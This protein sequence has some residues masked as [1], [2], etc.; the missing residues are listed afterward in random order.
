MSTQINVVVDGGG[1]VDRSKEQTQANRWAKAEADA[2]Q[3]ALDEGFKQREAV[4]KQ[5]GLSADSEPLYGAASRFKRWQD[6]PTA[7]LRGIDVGVLGRFSVYQNRDGA[8]R[9][10]VLEYFPFENGA[11][12]ET[13]TLIET[14]AS[15]PDLSSESLSERFDASANF[16]YLIERYPTGDYLGGAAVNDW[17]L[18]ESDIV[19]YP[20]GE[21]TRRY[22]RRVN[23]AFAY[24][25]ALLPVARNVFIWLVYGYAAQSTVDF[26]S[27]FRLV[28]DIV[29]TG[30][31][32][33]LP[34][35]SKL[36]QHVFT[37]RQT[38]LTDERLESFD[39]ISIRKAFLVNG[40]TL[41]PISFPNGVWQRLKT[42]V[43]EPLPPLASYETIQ[44][45]TVVGFT[46]PP[47]AYVTEMQPP[48]ILNSTLTP[49]QVNASYNISS[50]EDVYSYGYVRT[51]IDETLWTPGVYSL[52][53]NE[54]IPT[55]SPTSKG[56][57][58]V[59]RPNSSDFQWG[60]VRPFPVPAGSTPF[61]KPGGKVY[62]S[63]PYAFTWDW[64]QPWYCRQQL[65]SLGFALEDLT[66]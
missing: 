53:K 55:P 20:V 45:E 19:L 16:D 38:T 6:E 39:K 10:W 1:L 3:A 56:A 24:D 32:S 23:T 21:T 47:L 13:P 60:S 5:Q 15:F 26:D 36:Y 57:A 27:S 51:L 50:Y 41:R 31:F 30:R 46:D 59:P 12:S 22:R 40:A 17:Q 35:G 37:Q 64:G 43:D 44:T 8:T 66:P 9:K 48:H 61:P 29:P 62:P 11:V 63:E 7:F 28:I 18:P 42:S 54:S 52:L 14:L 58:P 4:L 49:Q 33:E 25:T 65:L 34:D 2:R